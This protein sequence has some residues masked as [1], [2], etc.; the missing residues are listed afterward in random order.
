MR[1]LF[2]IAPLL[3]CSLAMSGCASVSPATQAVVA[4][5]AP[6]KLAPAPAALM[7]QVPA[8]FGKQM[9]TFLFDS[10]TVPTSAQSR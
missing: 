10:P 4:C 7:Q 5:P 2:L 1:K 6:P 3:T 9:R 8:D